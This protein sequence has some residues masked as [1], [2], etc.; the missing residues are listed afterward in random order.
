MVWAADWMLVAR[1]RAI[2]EDELVS[3]ASL[4]RLPRAGQVLW[5][6]DWS[7]LLRVVRR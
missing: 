6:D 1:G 3:A 7:N 5:T 4:P 2:F